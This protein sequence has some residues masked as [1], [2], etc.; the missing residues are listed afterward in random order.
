MGAVGSSPSFLP[1]PSPCR[2]SADQPALSYVCEQAA[3]TYPA[4]PLIPKVAVAQQG[5]PGHSGCRAGACGGGGAGERGAL[6]CACVLMLVE[7]A[8]GGPA[9]RFLFPAGQGAL[10]GPHSG[11]GPPQVP[12]DGGKMKAM[13]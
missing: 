4:A 12:P 1:P 8:G 5:S 13:I 7:R 10:M 3:K 6:G 9:P 2:A 11:E